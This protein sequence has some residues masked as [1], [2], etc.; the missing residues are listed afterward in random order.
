M[1]WAFDVEHV[2]RI[3]QYV[4]ARLRERTPNWNGSLAS[5]LPKWVKD[6]KN[7]DAVLAACARLRELAA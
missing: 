5:R 3:E 4:G 7:R 1:L 2:D 6:R